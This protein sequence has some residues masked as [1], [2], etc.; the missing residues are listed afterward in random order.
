MEIRKMLERHP[1]TLDS[2]CK[3]CNTAINAVNRMLEG[4]SPEDIHF[5]K[6]IHKV[7]YFFNA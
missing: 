3:L 4:V 5:V 7:S 6:D 1:L 2:Q